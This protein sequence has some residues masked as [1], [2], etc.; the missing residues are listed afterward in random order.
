MPGIAKFTVVVLLL[1]AA[2]C[3][4]VVRSTGDIV[5]ETR[6][7]G[8]FDGVELRGSADLTI[9]I[10]EERSVVVETDRALIDSISTTVVDGRLVIDEG[11]SRPP[12]WAGRIDIT[13]TTPALDAIQLDG[14]GT[15]AARGLS[16]SLA[17][18]L[19][20]SGDIT[21]AGDR[22]DLV[23]DLDGSGSI[24]AGGL[25]SRSASVGGDGSGDIAVTVEGSALLVALGGSMSIEA[26][27][28]VDEAVIALDGSGDFAGRW[29]TAG[30]ASVVISGSGG[31]AITV[32]DHLHAAI[33]GSGD[34]VY[35]GAPEV[36]R[37]IS[38]SGEVR[39]G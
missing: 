10:G 33:T 35:H 22:E 34:V 25:I 26:G 2:A 1:T 38:G 9:E 29:L 6:D 27:G 36:S 3:G 18:G 16:A 13:V 4:D 24:D 31:V 20:G 23:I 8:P 28:T 17:V 30:S 19:A 32:V 7:V 15:V 14:S 12:F 37:E 39:R 21:V 5:S 11:T